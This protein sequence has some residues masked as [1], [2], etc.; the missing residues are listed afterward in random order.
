MA[1]TLSAISVLLVFL[2]FL[3]HLIENK[4]SA[5][6]EEKKPDEAKTTEVKKYYYKLNQTLFLKLIPITFIYLVAFYV[7]L[8]TTVNIIRN[9]TFSLWNFDALETLFVCI[10]AGLLGLTI[11][12]IYRIIELIKKINK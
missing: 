1:D 6:I 7:L 4:V 2:T 12:A 9:S 11:Y 8:P 5:I 10:E 3:F